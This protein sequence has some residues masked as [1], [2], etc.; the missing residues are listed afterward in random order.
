MGRNRN[1]S[2]KKDKVPST[3]P[4]FYGPGSTRSIQYAP[5]AKSVFAATGETPTNEEM[6]DACNADPDKEVAMDSHEASIWLDFNQRVDSALIAKM[7]K[8]LADKKKKEALRQQK[9]NNRTAFADTFRAYVADEVGPEVDRMTPVEISGLLHMLMTPVLTSKHI[10]KGEM[11]AMLETV[12]MRKTVFD[13]MEEV[14]DRQL[15]F[16][17]AIRH[18]LQTESV[19]LTIEA[20]DDVIGRS[21]ILKSLPDT[22]TVLDAALIKE[23]I[24]THNV[25]TNPKQVEKFR[26]QAKKFRVQALHKDLHKSLNSLLSLP[27]YVTMT[28][29]KG[30][31]SITAAVALLLKS[32]KVVKPR[33]VKGTAN[34][35]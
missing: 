18:Q 33:K 29:E 17:L 19:D 15:K 14:V 21:G 27:E 6:L 16:R 8:G 9:D 20:M 23:L 25:A 35:E 7:Q 28:T 5:L 26:V 4:G 34:V 2:S 30:N 3:K 32:V 22:D 24:S 1:N 10:D 12:G 31:L 13:S 11:P